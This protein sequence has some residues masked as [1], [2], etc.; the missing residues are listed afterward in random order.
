MS[1]Q[2][3]FHFFKNV[4]EP[5]LADIHTVLALPRSC[6]PFCLVLDHSA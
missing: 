6:G 4:F 5:K 1:R 2:V 3:L